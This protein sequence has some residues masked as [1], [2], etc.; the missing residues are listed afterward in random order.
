MNFF[1]K[2][3]RVFL[4]AGFIILVIGIGY[5][6]YAVFI[7]P[8]P[9]VTP[10]SGPGAT[11]TTGQLPSAKPGGPIATGTPAGTNVPSA[12]QTT[13]DK[14][15]QGGLTQTPQVTNAQALSPTLSGS[16]SGVQYYNQSDGKFYRLDAAGNAIPLSD[17]VFFNVNNVV[18]SPQK[19]KAILEYPDGAKILYNFTT[20]NQIT[21]PSHWQDFNFSPDGSKI[22]LKS[23]SADPENNVLAIANDNGSAAQIIEPIGNNADTV[24][25]SWSPNNQTIAM[26]TQGVDAERQEVFFVGKNEENFKSTVVE[27]RGF[28]PQWSPAGDR[29]AYSVFSANTNL[30]PELWTVDAEGDAIGNDRHDL[31]VAT[32]AD[33]CAFSSDEIMYC[34]VPVT[35]DPGAGLFPEMAKN[36]SD[37]LYQIN[38][39]TGE[40]KLIAV[41]DGNFNMSNLVVTADGGNLYFT[42]TNTNILHK[43]ELK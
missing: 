30:K 10:P 6:L 19:D 34:G 14:I 8:A 4:I 11:S 5:L 18:W 42:D 17:Q 3:Q 36:T 26:Y 27:G 29:L 1:I 35:L 22:V 41:P 13:A 24:I 39:A 43:I 12:L 16:G 23:M 21:L 20:Q 25:S 33:K 2:Y 28:Q 32:W 15:A 7:K 40:K 9:T 31:G 37:N 38:I